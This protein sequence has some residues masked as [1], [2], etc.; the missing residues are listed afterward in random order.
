MY[1]IKIYTIGKTKEKW[2]DAA[3]QEYTK[4]LSSDLAI[5]WILCKDKESLDEHVKKMKD[6]ICLDPKGEQLESEEFSIFLQ[7]EFQK[8]GLRLNFVIG[9]AEGLDASQL[10]KATH[11]LSLSK[12]TFTHQI[13]R[14]ILLE[15][16][17]RAFQIQKGTHY[18]K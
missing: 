13:T 17:Y 1:K 12:L 4:R 8:Y 5:E 14:L 3:L 18:H 15:Q 10:T 7:K 16:L 2:L 6:F 11:I 9:G